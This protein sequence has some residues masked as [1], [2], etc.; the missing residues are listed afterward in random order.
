M[1]RSYLP[2]GLRNFLMVKHTVASL[3]QR[4]TSIILHPCRIATI[5]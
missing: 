5:G 1:G 2:A 3:G 4:E